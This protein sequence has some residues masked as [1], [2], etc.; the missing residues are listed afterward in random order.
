MEGKHAALSEKKEYEKNKQIEKSDEAAEV[1]KTMNAAIK[2]CWHL[3][4]TDT[5]WMTQDLSSKPDSVPCFRF[6]LK[7]VPI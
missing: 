4:A 6:N 7:P 3:N 5:T 1:E 2:V